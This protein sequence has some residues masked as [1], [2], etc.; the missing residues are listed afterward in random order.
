MGFLSWG[1]AT[2]MDIMEKGPIPPLGGL[3]LTSSSNPLLPILSPLVCLSLLSGL[4]SG[5]KFDS[6]ENSCLSQS[7]WS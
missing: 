5:L 2:W 6:G 1:Q 7:Y 4:V 3:G